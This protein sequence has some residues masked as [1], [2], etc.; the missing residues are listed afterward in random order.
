MK[1]L[2][3]LMSIILF[4]GC[5]VTPYKE[6]NLDTTSNFKSPKA[7]KAGVYVYQW[8]TI[9]LRKALLDV[10]FEIKGY[11]EISLNTAEYGYLELEPGDYEYKI[12]GGPFTQYAP[13]KF[14]AN[15]NYFF[16]AFSISFTDY[17]SLIRDQ[18]EI[19]MAKKIYKMVFMKSTP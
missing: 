14:E 7:G 19:D 18:F 9:L 11:P 5:T 15:E 8:K 12:N 17:S 4:T 1:F 6:L 16:R 13:V 3:I 2:I 10:D